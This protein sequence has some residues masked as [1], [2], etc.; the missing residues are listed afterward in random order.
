MP[1][2]RTWR[3]LLAVTSLLVFP[4]SSVRGQQTD[5]HGIHA[6]P[7]PGKVTIDGKL[8][9]WDL[10]GQ[11]LICY[12]LESLR[13]VYSAQVGMMYDAAS[14]YVALHWK[15][16]TPMGNSHDPRS[17]TY[18]AATV[19]ERFPPG[20]L[21]G[22]LRPVARQDRPHRSRGLLVLRAV[23]GALHRHRL[24]QEPDRALRRRREEALPHRGMEA[25]RRSR[26]GVPQGPRRQGLRPGDQAPLGSHHQ[27]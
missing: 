21:G 13:D 18:R 24:R 27:G 10:S 22:R 14:L 16:A 6:V 11:V 2:G 17:S 26:D 5:N 8:D 15:D 7:T 1:R 9:D 12:D 23:P 3:V 19:R 25:Q 4:G 20:G